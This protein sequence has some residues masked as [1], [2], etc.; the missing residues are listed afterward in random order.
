MPENRKYF[1]DTIRILA[2]LL[3]FISHY[4]DYFSFGSLNAMRDLFAGT[5]GR[6]GV[7]IFFAVSG[8]LVANSLS[9]RYGLLTYYAGRVIRVLLPYNIAYFSF[10]LLILSLSVFDSSYFTIAPL[11]NIITNNG[12]YKNIL[13]VIFGLDG[14]LNAHFDTNFYFFT[15]EWFIG[16]IILLYVISPLIY[17]GIKTNAFCVVLYSAFLITTSIFSFSYATNEINNAYW[18]FLARLPEFYLGMLIYKFN[19]FLLAK[20]TI[21]LIVLLA[22]SFAWCLIRI[23]LWNDTFIANSILP[24]SPWSMFFS[25][26]L[27]GISFILSNIINEKFNMSTINSF[28]KYS[29]PFMLLQHV[30]INTFITRF[31]IE[32]FS[33]FG[34]LAL[35][36]IFFMATAATAIFVKKISSPLEI[37]A[38]YRIKCLRESDGEGRLRTKG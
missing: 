34:Y 33:A 24:M 4:T 9:N 13:P 12:D 3:V 16:T 28:S 31:P 15:G 18:F 27:I 35:M 20:R 1:I 38:L 10:S 25:L 7:S 36:F 8:Y 32:S 23:S 29:Y 2:T 22:L 26:P 5:L 21:I 37:A 14:I 6:I 17:N 19:A 30:V 11:S